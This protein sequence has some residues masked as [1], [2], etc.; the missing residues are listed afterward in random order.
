MRISDLRYIIEQ[1]E[2]FYIRPG[3]GPNKDNK[4]V[5]FDPVTFR[6]IRSN[7]PDGSEDEIF[8]PFD[9]LDEFDDFIPE[10]EP[11]IPWWVP[12]LKYLPSYLPSMSPLWI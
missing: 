12:M 2:P 6:P 1:E 5:P 4:P 8:D 7:E 3:Y 9:P 10:P 11:E